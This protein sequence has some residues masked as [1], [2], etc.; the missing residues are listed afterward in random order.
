MQTP[1]GTVVSLTDRAEGLRAAIEVD[2][3]VVCPRCAAGRGCGAGILGAGRATKRVEV[4]VDPGLR[5]RKGDKV[6]LQLAPESILRASVFVYGI[7]LLG[8]VAAAAVAYGLSLGELGSAF[9]AIAGLGA[10]LAVSRRRLR[11][12]DCLREFT[13]TVTKLG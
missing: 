9:A 13:P 5:L 2:A 8:A 1:T 6:G 3:A 7:P 10:G 11:R 12:A 4:L